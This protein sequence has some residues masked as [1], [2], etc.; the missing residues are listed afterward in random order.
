MS[1]QHTAS[2]PRSRTTKTC[3]GQGICKLS[4]DLVT[5]SP[6]RPVFAQGQYLL[7]RWIEKRGSGHSKYMVGLFDAAAL[8]YNN[9]ASR[10]SNAT[11]AGSVVPD[12]DYRATPA[13]SAFSYAS[14]ADSE[15]VEALDLSDLSLLRHWAVSVSITICRVPEHLDLWQRVFPEIGFDYPFVNRAILSVAALHL[16]SLCLPHHNAGLS[17]FRRS[18]ASITAENSEALFVWSLFNMIYVFGISTLGS[19]RPSSSKDLALGVDWI[20]MIH[21]ITAVLHRTHDYIRLG[22]M[23]PLMSLGNWDDLDPGPLTIQGVDGHFC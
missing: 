11:G 8:S 13:S 9:Q 3:Y 12:L 21:G 20:P 2:I 6:P 5:T 19:T 17:G 18:V 10:A 16:A 4:E 1:S 14:P 7:K 22:R 23:A 15:T